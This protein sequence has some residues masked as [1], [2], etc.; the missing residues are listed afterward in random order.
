MRPGDEVDVT[1]T[2]TDPQ[3]QPVAAEVSL[4]L[5]E[6]SLLERF[7]WPLPSIQEFFR[8]VPREPAVRTTSSV[9]FTYRPTTRAIDPQ[10]LAEQDRLEL[11]REEEASRALGLPAL[12][13]PLAATPEA[14]FPPMGPARLD[15]RAA[16]SAELDRMR[17]QMS[18][19]A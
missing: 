16:E 2:T 3:G 12:G 13:S 4:A 17:R 18:R 19:P 15:N 9:T 14:S 11:A 1:V 7:A 5:V 10:L 8:G 6:Q